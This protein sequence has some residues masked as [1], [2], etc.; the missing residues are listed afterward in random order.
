MCNTLPNPG[1]LRVS[2]SPDL[3]S[4]ELRCKREVIYAL[5]E[6][7]LSRLNGTNDNLPAYTRRILGSFFYWYD[8]LSSY[9]ITCVL[10]MITYK[11]KYNAQKFSGYSNER[12]HPGHSPVDIFLI[13]LIHDS[14]FPHD[15]DSRKNNSFLIRG[16]PRFEICRCPLCFPELTLKKVK[17]GK[18]GY[19]RYRLEFRKITYLPNKTSSG[20]FSNPFQR[21]DRVLCRGFHQDGRTSLFQSRQ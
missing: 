20:N 21:K 4:L 12:F 18:F 16:R 3:A 17:T 6:G 10:S 2:K 8:I 11:S 15:I 1:N 13:L 7:R 14:T 9:K 5:R 19:L